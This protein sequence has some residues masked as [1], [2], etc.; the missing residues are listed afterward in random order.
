MQTE[1]NPTLTTHRLIQG[2]AR[3]LGFIASESV[4]LVVTSPPYWI[5]KR[6]NESVGQLGHVEDYEQFERFVLRHKALYLLQRR[7]SSTA[8]REY[9]EQTG[10]TVP[11]LGKF[12]KRRLHV[13][14]ISK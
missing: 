14:K 9:T 12:K 8:L 13:T 4:H 11:G 2:D 6:Y 1:V 10:K 3:H 7:V 5:L